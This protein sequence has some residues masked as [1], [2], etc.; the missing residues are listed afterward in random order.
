MI[1]VSDTS[2]ITSLVQIGREQIL[3]F[4]F[5]RV[6]IP[7][8]VRDELMAFH[9]ILPE[10]IEVSSAQNEAEVKSLLEILDRGEAEAIV[11]AQTISPDFLL[12]DDLDARAIASQ[13][14]LTI[15][16]LLG[17]LAHAKRRGFVTA[18]TQLIEQLEKQAGF[19]ISTEL[20]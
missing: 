6:L 10:F 15:I 19:R 7:P 14:G 13:R 18:L 11:L 9:K 3:K 17:V 4:L 12:V 20:K 1:V 2:A 16:G 5:D 8:A